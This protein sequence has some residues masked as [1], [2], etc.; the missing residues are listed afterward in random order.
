VK[1]TK[2]I[3]GVGERPVANAAARVV[4]LALPDD[5]FTVPR[6]IGQ[7]AVNAEIWRSFAPDLL[8]VM[9]VVATNASAQG[10]C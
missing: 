6:D 8:V 10:A 9:L 4:E 2:A 1:T 3:A 5:A 7:G